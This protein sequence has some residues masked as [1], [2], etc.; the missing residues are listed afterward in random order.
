MPVT[1]RGSVSG[2]EMLMIPHCLENW[3]TEGDEFVGLTH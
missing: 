1:G 2:C 3:L